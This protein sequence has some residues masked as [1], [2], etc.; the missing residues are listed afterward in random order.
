MGRPGDTFAIRNAE[1]KHL[2]DTGHHETAAALGLE[3]L[4]WVREH[5][6]VTTVCHWESNLSWELSNLGRFGE[7]AD[8]ARQSLLRL[9]EPYLARGIWAFVI[10]NLS[11]ALMEMG[12]WDEA[13]TRLDQARELDVRGRTRVVL[14]TTA[15]MILS[16]RGETSVAEELLMVARQQFPDAAR[17]APD[18]HLTMEWLAGAIAV[19][20]H[21][22]HAARGHL[23]PLLD[24]PET[25]GDEVLWRVLLLAAR[26]EGDAATTPGRRTAAGQTAQRVAHLLEVGDQIIGIGDLG[27]AWTAQ[28]AADCARASGTSRSDLW[29]AAVDA[30]HRTGQCH[31]HGWALVRLAECQLKEARR[32]EAQTCLAAAIE[33]GRVLRAVPLL[34]A[35]YAVGRRGRVELPVQDGR[36]ATPRR[37]RHGLTTREVEVLV[38]LAE[39]CSNDQIAKKLFISPKTA[40]VHVSR[41]LAKLGVASRT[42][43]AA[44]A[45]REGLLLD[46][47][48]VSG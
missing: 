8:L 27:V 45:H 10:E 3:L 19:G 24:A 48:R 44:V 9:G 26:V 21:D 13:A 40:S 47:E 23:L 11:F 22:L 46:E 20:R 33:T 28:L 18:L 14:D 39:G 17:T 29:A 16:Y 2:A 37:H 42:E 34:D 35:A 36:P 4:P 5:F 6:S 43:A 1:R 32:E 25:C 7:A 31:D 15:G 41:I 38:L 30:W 12:A